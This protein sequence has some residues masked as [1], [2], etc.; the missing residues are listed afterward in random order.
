M[1]NEPVNAAFNKHNPVMA[2]NK[3]VSILENTRN[4][5]VYIQPH[6]Q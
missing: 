1:K 6:S 2:N 5:Q 4:K 3:F